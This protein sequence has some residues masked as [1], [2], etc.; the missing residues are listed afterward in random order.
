[1]DFATFI[2]GGVVGF[3][4]ATVIWLAGFLVSK[5][6]AMQ[7]SS[8]GM[9][10]AEKGRMGMRRRGEGEKGRSGS[11]SDEDERDDLYTDYQN[12]L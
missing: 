3:V 7:E 5:A 8:W 4:V 6:V 10:D 12:Q 1:M 2:F 11:V 9:P